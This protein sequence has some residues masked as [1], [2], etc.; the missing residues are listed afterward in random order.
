MK[1]PNT[2]DVLSP[3]VYIILAVRGNSEEIPNDD[4]S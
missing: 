1:K 4:S 2:C 3:E